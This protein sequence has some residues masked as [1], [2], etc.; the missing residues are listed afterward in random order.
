[1]DRGKWYLTYIYRNTFGG[2]LAGTIEH[3]EVPLRAINEDEAIA[4][5]R[6]VWDKE[7]ERAKAVFKERRAWSH[8]PKDPFDD[9]P[10]NPYVIYKIPLDAV[11][12]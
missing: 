6:M 1:M 8:P 4:E 2:G 12:A 5:A 11:A 3:W 7:I 10:W 9:G